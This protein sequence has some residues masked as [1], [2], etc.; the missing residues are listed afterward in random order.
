MD[1]SDNS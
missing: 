1:R